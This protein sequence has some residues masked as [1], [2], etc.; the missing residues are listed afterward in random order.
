M[1]KKHFSKKTRLYMHVIYVNIYKWPSKELKMCSPPLVIKEI[2][3][4]TT[5][6]YHFTSSRKATVKKLDNSKCWQ[7]CG[8]IG[9]IQTAAENVIRCSHFRK[10]SDHSSNN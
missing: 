7:E 3:I 6:R 8:E 9:T 1:G 10:Q 2:Q 5:M 4:K